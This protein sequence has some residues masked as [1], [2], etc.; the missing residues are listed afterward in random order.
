MAKIR[1]NTQRPLRTYVWTEQQLDRAEHYTRTGQ[2]RIVHQ[3]REDREDQFVCI[4]DCD[5]R[6]GLLLH[7]L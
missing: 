6:V 7:F 4:V 2:M 3:L 5:D 1:R